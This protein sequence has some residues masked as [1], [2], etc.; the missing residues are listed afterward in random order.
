SRL[1]G[2][3]REPH[4][5]DL[6][7]FLNMCGARISGIGGSC[8]E[9]KGVTG[10]RGCEFVLSGDMI[11]AGTYLIMGAATGGRVTVDGVCVDELRSL[12][13]VFDRMGIEYTCDDVGVSVLGKGGMHGCVVET[14]VY[15][16]FP[17]D[18][19]PQVAALMGISK[20]KS[21]IREVVYGEHRFGYLEGLKK[22][23][24][25]AEAVGNRI[26]ITGRECFLPCK[27]DA[28]DLRGGAALVTAALCARGESRVGR[29]K[30]IERGYSFFS[31][32]LCA[33]GA[34]VSELV[35]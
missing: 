32:K 9:V 25:D 31:K 13:D 20:G 2:C 8:L 6:A 21:A 35:Q 18:L 1:M 4:V 28:V 17:T 11:E 14:G 15:P 29:G 30:Y 33:L 12:L 34:D 19:Q 16:G 27:C 5:C 7:R 23:G 10:L 24:M 3:A 22:F 26:E